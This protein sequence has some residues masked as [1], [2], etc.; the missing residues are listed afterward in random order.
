MHA[1]TEIAAKTPES[2]REDS[3]F[4]AKRT[5]FSQSA[6][7]SVDH[8]LHLQR[9][10]GNQAVQ[11]LFQSGAIQT[12][13][14][15]GQ[16]GDKSEQEAD[17]VA[18]QVVGMP[19]SNVSRKEDE[20]EVQ[21][22]PVTDLIT[23]V[24]QRQVEEEE[25]TAIHSKGIPNLESNINDL[26]G[27]GRPL[28]SETRSFFEPRFGYDFS[29]VRLHTDSNAA[30]TAKSIN[31]RAFTLGS[32]IVFG[33]GEYRPE[34][35]QGKR[36]LGHELTHVVQQDYNYKSI[37]SGSFDATLR[38]KGE[39]E[40]EKDPLEQATQ[41]DMLKTGELGRGIAMLVNQAGQLPPFVLNQIDIDFKGPKL[42]ELKRRLTE[43]QV[44]GKKIKPWG[45]GGKK[46][47]SL[48]MK[49]GEQYTFSEGQMWARLDFVATM[50]G[51]LGSV[52]RVLEHFGAIEQA[53]VPGTVWL[54]KSAARR[55]EATCKA[56]GEDKFPPSYVAMQLRGRH[57]ERHGRGMLMHPVGYAIDYYPYDTPMLTDDDLHTLL[58]AVGEGP[59]HMKL[60]NE[61]G[62]ELGHSARDAI[63]RKLGQETVRGV[64]ASKRDPAGQKLLAQVDQAYANMVGTSERFQ[65][66]LADT[67]TQRKKILKELKELRSKYNS[68]VKPLEADVRKAEAAEAAAL[69]AIARAEK[70][71]NK[72]SDRWRR[73]ERVRWDI[74]SWDPKYKKALDR[75]YKREEKAY[76]AYSKARFELAVAKELYKGSYTV[77]YR[78]GKY[79]ERIYAQRRLAQAAAPITKELK[80][81][82]APILAKLDKKIVEA[83]K[84]KDEA[85]IVALEGVKTR[86]T[87][88][89][90]FVFGAVV[91]D[92]RDPGVLQLLERGFARQDKPSPP[93]TRPEDIKRVFNS[94]FIKMMMEYGFE[95]GAAWR[96]STDTM[97]FNFVEGKSGVK[98]S[99]PTTGLDIL[100]TYLVRQSG[101]EAG[102]ETVTPE[103]TKPT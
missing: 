93:G 102:P 88:D 89:F 92:T 26:R 48:G 32:D 54:H 103:G 96:G 66:A 34:S 28:D 83:R 67:P 1:R 98:A 44:K 37:A 23:P 97:H 27:G 6:N 33:S 7:S 55:L 29:G 51:S 25:E 82:L 2:K 78:E 53:Q 18:D 15:F 69:R 50:S 72:A 56:F 30:E 31:A 35:S 99:S 71:A 73:A 10:I 86:L 59:T 52:S 39:G 62:K 68:D 42:E 94:S 85:D 84:R 19:D 76:R 41:I 64:E 77:N 79:W 40:Q 14:K 45:G 74:P 80:I 90:E 58:G 4:K 61:R 20:E 101:G 57:Q 17:R 5:D 43:E 38:K 60:T 81:L 24:A 22:K 9:T 8:I 3:V 95:P 65:G 91:K 47:L 36:L 100:F 13:L 21:T 70:K 49:A 16:P 46:K 63:V 87:S 75:A 12:K 11:R